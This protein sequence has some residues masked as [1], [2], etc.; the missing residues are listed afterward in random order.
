[1]RLKH[2]ILET[3]DYATCLQIIHDFNLHLD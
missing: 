2:K 1:M 3:D